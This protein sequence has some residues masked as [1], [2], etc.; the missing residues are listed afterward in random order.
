MTNAIDNWLDE[1]KEEK[2]K[3]YIIKAP[4]FVMVGKKRF[5][6]NMNKYRISHFMVLNKAKKEYKLKMHDQITLLPVFNKISLEYQFT[7][8]NK[9]LTDT[10]N[11]ASIQAKFFQDALVEY[12]RISDDNYTKVSCNGYN[13]IGIDKHNAR[14]DII[15]K[16][17]P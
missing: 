5:S 11:L 1:I 14:C 15:I 8:P 12:G 16:E 6:I 4:L 9:R 7:L 2:P 13:V 3:Q 17:L 10:D